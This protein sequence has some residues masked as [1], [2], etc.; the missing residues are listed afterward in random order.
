MPPVLTP[1]YKKAG[2][3][4]GSVNG[5]SCGVMFPLAYEGAN[6]DHIQAVGIAGAIQSNHLPHNFVFG[7]L[8]QSFEIA[9]IQSRQLFCFHSS[10]ILL[11][12]TLFF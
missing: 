3:S 9:Y 5:G 10:P 1:A 2:I 12:E 7:Y 6:S 4:A 8:H 11:F